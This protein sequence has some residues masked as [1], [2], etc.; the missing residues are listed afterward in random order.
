MNFN[1]FLLAIG[2]GM[3]MLVYY[4]AT[5]QPSP[6]HVDHEITSLPI[7]GEG[8]NGDTISLADFRRKYVVVEVW[9]PWSKG[10]P[11]TSKKILQ[12]AYRIRKN[13]KSVRLIRYALDSDRDRWIQAITTSKRSPRWIVNVRDP[14]G[15]LSLLTQRMEIKKLPY[16]M[17][18]S[19]K[20]EL[21]YRGNN[22]QHAMAATMERIKKKKRR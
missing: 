7:I 9:A 8:V 6:I 12:L 20:G 3:S 13:K 22:V 2:I 4:S 18:F 14:Y 17:V 16:L 10:C 19:P 5:G 21:I 1:Q 15:H 11:R